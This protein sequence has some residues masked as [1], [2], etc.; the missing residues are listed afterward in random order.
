MDALIFWYFNFQVRVAGAANSLLFWMLLV[1]PPWD[2]MK[3]VCSILQLFASAGWLL[4]AKLPPFSL[5][6]CSVSYSSWVDARVV[7]GTRN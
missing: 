5:N 6:S 7:L 4:M 1:L 3:S 2:G